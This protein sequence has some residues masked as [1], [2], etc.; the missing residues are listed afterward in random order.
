VLF[1]SLVILCGCRRSAEKAPTVNEEQPAAQAK[2]S[3]IINA[4]PNPVPAGPEKFGKT[5]IS[6][7]TGD[8]SVGQVFVSVNG[9]E[10]QLFADNR[11]KGVHEAKFIGK[12]ECVFRLYA[13]K[14][15]KTVLASVKVT[16]SKD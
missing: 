5:T 2:G 1:I 16:R 7:D 13:R 15:H 3:P 10:E 6:W 11:P 8:G 9:R 14:E 12:G 4:D